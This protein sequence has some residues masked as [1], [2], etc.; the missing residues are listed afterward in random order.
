[1]RRGSSDTVRIEYAVPKRRV[2]HALARYVKRIRSRVELHQAILFGSYARGNYSH[3]SDVDV[4]VIAD[5][6]PEDYGERY[7]LLKETVL[8]LDLQPFA[9]TVKE[10]E[11]MA[12]TES[13]FVQ[14]ILRHGKV[15]YPPG[16][17]TSLP[18]IREGWK[19]LKAIA[20]KRTEKL[21]DMTEEEIEQ[22]VRKYRHGKR[23]ERGRL[24]KLKPFTREKLTRIEVVKIPGLHE[25]FA[26]RKT[27]KITTEEFESMTSEVIGE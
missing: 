7:A 3:D 14:E 19:S 12:R 8:G 5:R 11:K 13:G 4:A 27:A 22:T 9:Y 6:L 25:A 17:R 20:Q 10:W 24:P 15:I 1:M 2:E 16:S 26:R 23:S 21:G 18:G